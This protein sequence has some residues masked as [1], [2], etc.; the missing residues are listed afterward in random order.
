MDGPIPVPIDDVLLAENVQ[1]INICD[2]G[3]VS[4]YMYF[5]NA[6]YFSFFFVSI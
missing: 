2:T 3:V 6:L 4:L 5:L 1:N